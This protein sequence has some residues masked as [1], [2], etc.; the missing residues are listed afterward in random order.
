MANLST[1][2]ASSSCS[3][4]L[5]G[6]PARWHLTLPL[7]TLRSWNLSLLLLLLGVLRVEMLHR[8]I[9]I[10]CPLPWPLLLVLLLVLLVLLSSLWNLALTV[11]SEIPLLSSLL[12]LKRLLNPGCPHC[13]IQ[14]LR[15][16]HL[17]KTSKSKV[18]SSHK[19]A[20]SILLGRH[21]T[22]RKPLQPVKLQYIVLQ[23]SP[24]LRNASKLH[25]HIMSD[26]GR[27]VLGQNALSEHPQEI[28]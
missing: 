18:Q 13:I 21:K 9:S 26:V 23:R 14:G 27:K 25:L 3:L 28:C 19:V 7:L 11:S 5:M 1:V 4:L 24:T 15:L 17:N 8:T 10:T 22:G 12:S 16:S 20:G 6:L 2:E